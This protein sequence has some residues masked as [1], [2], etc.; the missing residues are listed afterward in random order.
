VK[1][2]LKFLVSLLLTV[3]L[4]WWAFRD[5]NWQ[6]QWESLRS[7]NYWWLVPYFAIL[8]TIHVFRTVRWGYLLS[9]MQKVKFRQLNE[10]SGIGFMMLLLLP[11]RLGEFARP[12]LIGQRSSIRRSAAMTSV[13]LERIVDG[14]SIAVLLR[15]LLFFVHDDTESVRFARWGANAMFTVFAGGLAFLLFAFWHQR[16]AVQL[17]QV[18]LGRVSQKLAGQAAHVVDTFVGALRH[19]PRGWQMVGFVFFTV[20]FWG[21]NGFG[22]YILAHAFDCSG[23][24]D[25]CVPMNLT[26]FQSY[27]VLSVL[28]VGLMIPGAPGMIG[29]FQAGLKLGLSLFLPAALLNGKGVAYANVMWLC[30][31]AQQIGLGVI[32]M[33]L[34]NVS[35][36]DVAGK[37]STEGEP[38]AAAGQREYSAGSP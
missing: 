7:A 3:V 12:F 10:A 11:F 2:L 13:V 20:A 34:G 27:V 33:S 37:L 5:T 28:V 31:T 24:T 4:G 6:E 26:L 25:G 29:T 36:R 38:P 23:A 1:R 18:T 30:Q 16:R 21:I 32:L 19:I 14:M 8:L 9:G 17:V 35:F 15:V 22:M